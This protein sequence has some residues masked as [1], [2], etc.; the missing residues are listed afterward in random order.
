MFVL[1]FTPFLTWIASF[2]TPLESSVP[3]HRSKLRNFEQHWVQSAQKYRW[4]LH[5]EI[6][7][8][9]FHMSYF[10][11][12]SQLL[13]NSMFFFGTLIW[14]DLLKFY[15]SVL[16]CWQQSIIP[17]SEPWRLFFVLS[18]RR[19]LLHFTQY[20][21]WELCYTENFVQHLLVACLRVI[22]PKTA[23][24]CE[25]WQTGTCGQYRRMV[26]S[27]NQGFQ[28]SCHRGWLQYAELLLSWINL[29]Q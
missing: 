26:D 20:W 27:L 3:S 13:N 24:F 2:V 6:R 17:S 11:D 28:T 23:H 19:L 15:E 10:R 5:S 8:W 18:V 9:W 22:G 7:V 25:V 12:R 29:F 4:T 21:C 1:K 16:Q 14:F